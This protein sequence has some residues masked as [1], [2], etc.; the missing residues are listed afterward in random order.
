[1]A[2]A[3]AQPFDAVLM[4][5]QM[6][7][8]DGFEAT[9]AL[10]ARPELAGLPI[11][12][13]SAD[14]LPGVRERVLAA[15][16]DDYL[17]KPFE[18]EALLRALGQRR[19]RAAPAPPHPAD[20]AVLDAVGARARLGLDPDTYG[21]LVARFAQGQGQ[22]VEQLTGAVAAGDR[23]SALRHAHSLK[24]AASSIGA[25]RLAAAAAALEAVLRAAGAEA[26]PGPADQVRLCF[27]QFQAAMA[28][29]APAA[30][31]AELDWTALEGELDALEQALGRDDTSARRRAAHLE[32]LLQGSAL[33]AALAPVKRHVDSYEFPEA[34]AQLGAFAAA[35]AASRPPRKEV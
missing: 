34:L 25:S 30:A 8:M 5:L 14:V 17:T 10:R 22:L 18:V 23:D 26:W 20:P 15:G 1:V 32:Q 7:V 2:L 9:R 33:L 28:P 12:A 31:P 13:M 19:P 24:G 21:Q 11:I 35:V 16:M 27:A 3:S 29:A 4:D 6:P